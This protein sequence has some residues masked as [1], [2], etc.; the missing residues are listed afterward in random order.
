[1]TFRLR[2]PGPGGRVPAV[3]VRAVAPLAAVLAAGTLLAAYVTGCG[4]PDDATP[5]AARVEDLLAR[6]SLDDKIGQM[7][8]V[9]RAALDPVA[10]LTRYRI[11]AVQGVVAPPVQPDELRRAALAT[12][13]RI[14]ILA[15]VSAGRAG[16]RGEATGAATGVVFPANIG[17]GASRDPDLAQRVGRALAEQIAATGAHWS[18]GPCL[19]VARNDRWVRAA[20]SFGEKPEIAS[21]MTTMVTGLQGATLA[22]PASVL[23]TATG[24]IGDGATT[25]GIDEGDA[26]TSEADLRAIHLAPF[27]SAVQRGVAS[28]RISSGGWNGYRLHAHHYLI[29]DVLKRELGFT[30]IVVGDVVGL[31]SIDGQEGFTEAEVAATVNAGVDMVVVDDYRRFVALLRSAVRSGHV[32]TERVD[33]ATRR[34]LTKKFEL[35]LFDRPFADRGPAATVGPPDHR[36]LA[37]EAVRR[38]VVLLKNAG[39]VLPLT[40]G[41]RIFVAGGAADDLARQRGAAVATRTV[42]ST[43]APGTTILDGIRATAGVPVAYHRDGLGVD[44][45]YRAG[46]AVIGEATAPDEVPDRPATLVPDP[47]DLAAVDRIRAAGVPVV[48]VLVSGR[49]LDVAARLR[50]WDAL[51]AAWLPGSEGQGVADVLYGDHNPAARLPMTWM[52]AAGQQPI[53]DGDGKPPLFPYDFGLSYATTATTTLTAPPASTPPREPSGPGPPRTRPCSVEYRVVNQ[54]D[55]GFQADMTIRNTAPAGV[56]GWRLV[57][58]F[59]DGQRITQLWGGEATIRDGTVTVRNA[60]WNGELPPGATATVGFTASHTGRNPVPDDFRLN[61]AACLVR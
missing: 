27:R 60:D 10:D 4:R 46:V 39:R 3:V 57:W 28:V 19:C 54:W 40:R 6:M 45:S 14:P 17:L 32:A 13:L 21:A 31:D 22:G 47:R 48:V 50:G 7:T 43:R 8:R 41:D 2:R 38:S 29:T 34:V 26:L 59:G 24:F 37:R 5:V 30:G 1:M 33:D 56:K 58:R 52:S 20:E 18:S 9:D 61:G 16:E 42:V 53:N 15:S 12:P 44:S 55:V 25:D 23:A 51:L 35:G 11:G 49:P 36:D